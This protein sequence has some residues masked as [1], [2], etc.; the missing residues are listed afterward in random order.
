MTDR[1]FFPSME[2]ALI[3]A[4]GSVKI[5]KNMILLKKFSAKNDARIFRSQLS[6]NQRY[7]RG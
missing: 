5:V 2:S 1:L 3:A 7:R 6:H 4:C